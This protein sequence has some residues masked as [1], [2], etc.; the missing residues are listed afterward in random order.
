MRSFPFRQCE[1]HER[2]DKRRL[3]M[4][5][6]GKEEKRE[7]GGLQFSIGGV[8]CT[9]SYITRSLQPES[10]VRDGLGDER[11]TERERSCSFKKDQA[12]F[13]WIAAEGVLERA[14]SGKAVSI[15]GDTI[16]YD[17]IEASRR[18]RRPVGQDGR[19]ALEVLKVV[20]LLTCT[21]RGWHQQVH[22]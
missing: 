3:K 4:R 14:K 22:R 1:K 7:L 11:A 16:A 8:L 17:G 15:K 20:G 19:D 10:G 21:W 6:P 5:R 12:S 2:R 18:G 9:D 13:A